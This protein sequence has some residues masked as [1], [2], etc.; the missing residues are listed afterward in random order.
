MGLPRWENPG[1][2]VAGDTLAPNARDC[3]SLFPLSCPK[4]EQPQQRTS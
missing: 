1:E 3:A 2:I 4:R